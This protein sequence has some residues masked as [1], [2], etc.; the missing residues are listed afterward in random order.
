MAGAH[1]LVQL[2]RLEEQAGQVEVVR[3]D[4]EL[5]QAQLLAQ[6]ILAVVAGAALI[7]APSLLAQQAALAS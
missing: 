3:V 5:H 6:Q 7:Q 2:L 1:T 4:M